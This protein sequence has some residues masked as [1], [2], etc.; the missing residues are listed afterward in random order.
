M[1]RCLPKLYSKQEPRIIVQTSH[2]LARERLLKG[3][4]ILLI[5]FVIAAAVI[6]IFSDFS[7]EAMVMLGFA[8][9][10]LVFAGMMDVLPEIVRND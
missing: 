7:F 8:G 9:I 4:E 6:L 2:A 1:A 3:Y 10:A 5:A